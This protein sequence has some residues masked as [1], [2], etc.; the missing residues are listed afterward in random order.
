MTGSVGEG[1]RV[2]AGLGPSVASSYCTGVNLYL[3]ALASAVSSSGSAI[4][5][6]CLT[7]SHPA[8][9]C[10]TPSHPAKPQP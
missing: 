3:L 9:P 8:K 5:Y 10:L 4:F 7:P 6:F 2:S 1:G